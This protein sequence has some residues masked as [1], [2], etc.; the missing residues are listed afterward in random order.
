ME[1][2]WKVIGGY[3]NYAVSNFGR[4]KRLTSRNNAVAGKILKTHIASTGYPMV[5][6]LNEH[7]RRHVLVHRLVAEAFLAKP[8][9]ACEVNHIDANRAH[10][11]IS[12]LEWVTSSGNRLHAYQ[13]GGL[14]AKGEKNGYSKLTEDGVREIRSAWPLNRTQQATLAARLGVSTAT[15]RDVAARRTWAHI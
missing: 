4:I 3:P 9:E 8:A 1:E 5:N 14:S 6:L 13:T 2:Q 12:N 15:V 10:N 7:G 11:H